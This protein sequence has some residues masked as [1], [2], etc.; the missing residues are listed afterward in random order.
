VEAADAY[1]VMV[2]LPSG[3]GEGHWNATSDPS[4]DDLQLKQEVHRDMIIR[5]R[6][7]P[8][9]LDWEADNGGNNTPLANA[10][11]AL[12]TTWDNIA[13]R[14]QADRGYNPAWG[15]M[16][17][18]D[19]AGC[20]VAMKGS[21]P[22]N[23]AFGAEYWDNIGTGRGTVINLGGVSVSAYDYELAYSAPY[24]DDWRQGRAAN[25]FGMAQWYFADTPGEISTWAEF[26]NQP[27]MV[28]QQ[29]DANGTGNALVRSLGYSMVDQNRFPR[30]LYYVYQANW[31]PYSI[32]PVV[33]LAHHWNRAYEY[34]AGTPI[35]VNAF[36]NCP[37]VR[38]LV[39]GVAKDPVTGASL[40][41]MTPN[42]WNIDSHSDLSQS[43]TIMPS[44]VHWM[45]NWA[46][47]TATAECIGE[48]SNPVSGVSTR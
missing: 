12:S 41:D 7:H 40:A 28:N 27:L 31:V 8:S 13:P 20:E 15:F 38:L 48:D 29:N 25:T 5:D 43:T 24:I 35:Q 26:Q 34:T 9:I 33:H 30:L 36:S 21:N 19:G 1:G 37:A 45:V 44:Q 42:P 14:V 4:A 18:C 6:S 11:M 22:N 47:G 17:E 23:P 16:A 39:N 3:D 46:S 10:L 32:Q 2:D